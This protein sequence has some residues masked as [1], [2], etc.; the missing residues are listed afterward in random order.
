MHS[1]GETVSLGLTSLFGVSIVMD[2]GRVEV[3]LLKEGLRGSGSWYG[4][5]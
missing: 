5:R 4:P 2:A 3:V 1:G